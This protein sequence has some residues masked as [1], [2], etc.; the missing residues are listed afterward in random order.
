MPKGLKIVIVL[1]VLSAL[2]IAWG[3]VM[4]GG[5]FTAGLPLPPDEPV[6]LRLE[7]VTLARPIAPLPPPAASAPATLPVDLRDSAPRW[8]VDEAGRV[9]ILE[10]V[11]ELPPWQR[12][13]A[14]VDLHA[15]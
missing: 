13:T 8:Y 3:A 10:P 2:L 9:R 6:R 11:S 1:N 5:G 14:E 12:L 7:P 15:R 4:M